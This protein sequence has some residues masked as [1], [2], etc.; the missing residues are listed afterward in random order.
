MLPIIAIAKLQLVWGQA[1]DLGCLSRE[2][3]KGEEESRLFNDLV[4]APKPPI[5]GALSLASPKVVF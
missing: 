1:N 3:V 2:K 5:L 4:F